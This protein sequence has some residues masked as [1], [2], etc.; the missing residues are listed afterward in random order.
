MVG[1]T[2]SVNL[3]A[4]RIRGRRVSLVCGW[5]PCTTGAADSVHTAAQTCLRAFRGHVPRLREPVWIRSG[6]G[7]IVAVTIHSQSA[8]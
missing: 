3:A 7:S 8:G 5:P 2:L 1:S 4:R 6:M